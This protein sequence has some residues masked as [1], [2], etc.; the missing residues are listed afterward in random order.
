MKLRNILLYFTIFMSFNA[1][2]QKIF[3]E[4]GK[5]EYSDTLNIK[6]LHKVCDNLEIKFSDVY[7]D[8]SHSINFKTDKTFFALQYIIKSTKDGNLYTTKYL[9]A[10]NSNGRVID[11]IDDKESFYD[12]E[13]VQSSPSYILKN[14]IKF[15][16]N[17]IGIGI[18]TEKSARSCATLFSQQKISIISLSNNKITNLLDSY[19]IRKV[20]GESNCSGNYEIEILEKS[21]DLMKNKTNGLFDLLV[22]KIFTYEYVIEENLNKNIKE[23]KIV[24]NKTETE[25]LSFN[26]II[27]NF[28]KDEI[29]RFLKW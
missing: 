9:F 26:G 28:E 14:K 25:K 17:I 29:L 7:I 8:K 10:D 6:L 1:Y 5:R 22:K 19:I 27:Y 18:I 4:N 23:I 21:I 2:S 24:K 20:Q 3:K 13:A 11:Q 12:E 15:N 16:D